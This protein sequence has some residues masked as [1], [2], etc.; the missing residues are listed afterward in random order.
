ML[1]Q[2]YLII[3]EANPLLERNFL[4]RQKFLLSLPR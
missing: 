2:S 3:L 1:K 4:N